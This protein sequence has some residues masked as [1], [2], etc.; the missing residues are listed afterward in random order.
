[1]FVA[2]PPKID[3]YNRMLDDVTVKTGESVKLKCQ[4][5]GIPSPQLTWNIWTKT[6]TLSKRKDI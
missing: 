5:S 3:T 6:K 4:A 1:M 2:V